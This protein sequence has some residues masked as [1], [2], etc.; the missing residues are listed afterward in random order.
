[1]R[2][3]QILAATALASFALVWIWVATMPMAFMDPEYP[4]WRAKLVLLDRCDLGETVIVGDSRAA[5]DILP[6]LLPVKAT[7]LAVGGGES[8]EAYAALVRALACPVAPRLVI[9]SLDPGHFAN[10]DQWERSVRFGFVRDADVAMLRAAARETGDYS[11]YAGRQSDGVP[12]VLRDALYRL[13]FPPLYFASLVRSGGALRW[14]RNRDMLDATLAA[15]GHYYFGTEAGS[16]AVAVDGHLTEFHPL[17]VLDL[18]FDR[19]L[20]LLEARGIEAR[21]VPMPVN[22]ATWRE[23]RPAVRSAFVA[24]LSGYER[25]YK[26]FHVDQELTPHWPDRWFGDQFCHLNPEG[27]ER[28]SL[29]LADRLRASPPG[30]RDEA[31]NGWWDEPWRTAPTEVLSV[32]KSGS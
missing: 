4:A 16:G 29:L 3:L 19:I 25:R 6:S 23:I 31:R 8:I 5:A 13:H 24:Y 21:F 32:A 11:V 7:N 17:P 2:Y 30:T 9:I 26:L 18:Y 22:E 15:R 20:A 10:A 27:A 28:F 14:W 12:M 1:M